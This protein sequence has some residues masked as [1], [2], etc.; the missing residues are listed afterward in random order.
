MTETKDSS[1][2][3]PA[4][5]TKAPATNLGD[6]LAPTAETPKADVQPKAEQTKAPEAKA[7]GD[8]KSADA[9]G[10]EA[11]TL[12]DGYS[13]APEDLK[14]F[15]ELGQKYSLPQEGAQDIINLG[16]ALA[17]NTRQQVLAEQ[18]QEAQTTKQEWVSNLQKDPELGGEKFKDTQA[19]LNAFQQS[20][21]ADAAGLT[22]LTE[23]GLITNP[24]IARILSR[25]GATLRERPV[26]FGSDQANPEVNAARKLFANSKH[27]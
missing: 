17:E 10:Y 11:F 12:P 2:N 8:K 19:N 20:K 22:F 26:T 5:D 4:A 16:V 13:V 24:H 21:I 7:E 6:A 1:T 15:T 9:A 14:V 3:T 18:N 27:V 23:T 25:V